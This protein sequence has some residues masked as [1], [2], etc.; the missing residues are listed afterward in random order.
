MALR[1]LAVRAARAAAVAVLVDLIRGQ[2]RALL[3]EMAASYCAFTF[4]VKL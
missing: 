2:F 1:L 4:E 3:V